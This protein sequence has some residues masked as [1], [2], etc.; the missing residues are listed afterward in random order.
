MKT[1]DFLWCLP[2][3]GG[4]SPGPHCPGL[5]TCAS[6]PAVQQ[7]PSCLC[8]IECPRDVLSEGASPLFAFTSQQFSAWGTH[9]VCEPQCPSLPLHPG[10]VYMYLLLQSSL[11][12]VLLAQ[13]KSVTQQC[14]IKKSS[15][16]C[17]SCSPQWCIVV[18]DAAGVLWPASCTAALQRSKQGVQPQKS[19]VHPH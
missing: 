12:S 8:W 13:P 17:P 7:F 19:S 10:K 18:C 2:G 14:D 16:Q 6:S 1:A 9:T 11:A 15:C 5:L 3:P 4:L